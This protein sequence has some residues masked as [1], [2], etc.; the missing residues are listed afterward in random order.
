VQV[1]KLKTRLCSKLVDRADPADS[2]HVAQVAIHVRVL[3]R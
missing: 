1:G 2:A 3:R